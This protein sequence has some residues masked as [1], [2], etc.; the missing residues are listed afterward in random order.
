MNKDY[1]YLLMFLIPW[2]FICYLGFTG[3][4]EGWYAWLFIF[5]PPIF[6]IGM[7]IASIATKDE[8]KQPNEELIQTQR[9]ERE[10]NKNNGIT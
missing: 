6:V 7:K 3:K 2:L 4:I 10:K 5:G 9:E 1:L 8:F